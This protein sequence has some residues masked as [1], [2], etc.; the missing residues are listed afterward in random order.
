MMNGERN[1]KGSVCGEEFCKFD[2]LF[3]F[4]PSAAAAARIFILSLSPLRPSFPAAMAAITIAQ[5]FVIETIPSEVFSVRFSSDG[6]LLAAGCNDG[7]VR[8]RFFLP[9]RSIRA[10]LGGLHLPRIRPAHCMRN[11]IR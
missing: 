7:V 2:F 10:A 6:L 3:F 4:W 8:V 11:Y 9:R 5:R 1:G